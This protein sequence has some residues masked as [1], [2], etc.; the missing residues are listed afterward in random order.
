M[1][2][3]ITITEQQYKALVSAEIKLAIIKK[4]LQEQEIPDYNYKIIMGCVFNEWKDFK[5]NKG[6]IWTANNWI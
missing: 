6:K 4:I 5:N 3:E 2:N 1:D